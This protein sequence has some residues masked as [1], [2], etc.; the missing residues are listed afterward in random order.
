MY[1]SLDVS[2]CIAFANMQRQVWDTLRE[3]YDQ[4]FELNMGLRSSVQVYSALLSFVLLA[5]HGC[6][7]RSMNGGGGCCGEQM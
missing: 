5:D 6:V 4:G 1:L 3:A 7:G 2:N